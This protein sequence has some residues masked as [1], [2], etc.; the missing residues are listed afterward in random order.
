[1]NAKS[2]EERQV[3]LSAYILTRQYS[4]FMDWDE[5]DRMGAMK[6]LFDDALTIGLQH[7]ADTLMMLDDMAEK[8]D[9][10]DE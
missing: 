4:D 5:Q 10:G 8:K 7:I 3:Y 1:M 6:E 9:G 2:R